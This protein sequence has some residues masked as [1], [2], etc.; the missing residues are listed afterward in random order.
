[1]VIVSSVVDAVFKDGGLMYQ[2][3]RRKSGGV[4][5]TLSP[6]FNAEVMLKTVDEPSDDE[7]LV[8]AM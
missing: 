6:K 4:T 8:D 1:M 2:R 5:S 3:E 7:S